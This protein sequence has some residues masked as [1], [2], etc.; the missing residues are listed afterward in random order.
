MCLQWFATKVGNLCRYDGRISYVYTTKFRTG[1]ED[2]AAL[3]LCAEVSNGVEGCG[4][5][6]TEANIE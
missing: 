1:E 5:E 2:T 3:A 4:D 6:G